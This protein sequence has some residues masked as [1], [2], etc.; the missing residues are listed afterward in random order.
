MKEDEGQNKA[1]KGDRWK[2][3]DVDREVLTS[4]INRV[5]AKWI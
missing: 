3:E 1:F 5:E 4:V 2:G